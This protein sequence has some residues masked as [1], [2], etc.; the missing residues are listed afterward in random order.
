M[1]VL[2]NVLL[3]IILCLLAH[4]GGH[5]FAAKAFGQT[6]KFRFAWTNLFGKI[7]LPR[8]AWD[9]PDMEPWKQKAVALAGFAV[10]FVAALAAGSV[11]ILAA[12]I[13]LV[14]YRLCAG[15]ESDFKWL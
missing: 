9:M 15:E 8:I 6:L 10:E 1:N 2:I 11:F 3:A 12:G 7:S 14:L 4:E 13:H 5:F